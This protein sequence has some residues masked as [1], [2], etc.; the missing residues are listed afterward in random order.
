[1][2]LSWFITIFT[3]PDIVGKLPFRSAPVDRD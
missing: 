1:M 2:Y 3:S